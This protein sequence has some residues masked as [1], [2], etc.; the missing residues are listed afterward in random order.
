MAIDTEQ[1]SAEVRDDGEEGAESPRF[2]QPEN[3]SAAKVRLWKRQEAVLAKYGRYGDA[4]SA[5]TAA[6]VGERT[7]YDWLEAD[8]LGYRA[9]FDAARNHYADTR[10]R[11]MHDRLEDPQGNRGSDILLIFQLKGLRPDKWREAALTVDDAAKDT[12]KELRKL[13]REELRQEKEEKEKE[14]E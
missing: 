3:L 9:R 14:E 10:E 13:R 8:T 2:S 1:K 5:T 12:L 11:L 4:V 7:H 6:G